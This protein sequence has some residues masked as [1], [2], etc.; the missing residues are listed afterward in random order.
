VRGRNE[1]KVGENNG[2]EAKK[3]EE[4]REREEGKLEFY[5][6]NRRHNTCVKPF[7]FQQIDA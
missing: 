6:Q 4:R 1:E 7:L 5:P 2:I 3:K